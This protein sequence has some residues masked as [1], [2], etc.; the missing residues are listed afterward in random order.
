[1]LLTG[2]PAGGFPLT[3]ATGGLFFLLESPSSLGLCITRFTGADFLGCAGLFPLSPFN[4]LKKSDCSFNLSGDLV[5]L[6]LVLLSGR[7]WRSFV[8][9]SF[10][11]SILMGAGAESDV[12]LVDSVVSLSESFLSFS[13]ISMFLLRSRKGRTRENWWVS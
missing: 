2:G 4:F 10:C 7:Y 8:K 13:W 12:P 1:M 6:G 9:N 5:K 11:S 3:P